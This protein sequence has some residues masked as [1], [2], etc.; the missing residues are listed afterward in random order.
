[1]LNR[2]QSETWIR[3][4]GYIHPPPLKINGSHAI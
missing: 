1:M 4:A 3:I 2:Q